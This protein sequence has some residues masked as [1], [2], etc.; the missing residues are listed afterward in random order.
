MASQ[1]TW[2]KEDILKIWPRA[3]GELRGFQKHLEV[4]SGLTAAQLGMALQLAEIE[5]QRL[6]TNHEFDVKEGGQ[7]LI[8]ISRE[9]NLTQ[10]QSI[11][12]SAIIVS[13][14]MGDYRKSGKLIHQLEYESLMSAKEIEV[15]ISRY[16]KLSGTKLV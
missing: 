9:S 2:T 8:Q 1:R 14:L 16:E 13:M 5:F 3:K 7:N 15:A 11:L 4:K 6:Q 10:E 12:L